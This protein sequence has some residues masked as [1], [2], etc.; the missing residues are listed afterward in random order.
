MARPERT[1]MASLTHWLARG[2]TL[3]VLW[4]PILLVLTVL[5]PTAGRP[6]PQYG[7]TALALAL[8]AERVL[9]VL[10]FLPTALRARGRYRVLPRR[11]SLAVLF[12][13]LGLSLVGYGGW[14][15]VQRGLTGAVIAS[16]LSAALSVMGAWRYRRWAMWGGWL[17]V[18]DGLVSVEGTR[19]D[20]TVPLGQI[21]A[22]HHRE[23]DGSYWIET[24]WPERNT[25]V[26]TPA[27]LGRYWIEDA[28]DL[29]ND[30]RG[31]AEIREVKALIGLVAGRRT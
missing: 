9:R 23:R 29:L 1:W 24:P 7:L 12:G 25:L 2:V 16:L 6:S 17:E 20:Y 31:G 4:A 19:R 11:P 18:R 3:L 22:V 28:E 27:A 14:L 8:I 10:F 21:R 5:S 13:A 30:L 26:L 15:G